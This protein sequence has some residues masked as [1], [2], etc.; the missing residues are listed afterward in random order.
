MSETLPLKSWR[1]PETASTAAAGSKWSARAR[2]TASPI[3]IA[4]E[5]VAGTAHFFV[6]SPVMTGKAYPAEPPIATVTGRA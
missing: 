1:P 5:R 6:S 3:A 2:S 4:R